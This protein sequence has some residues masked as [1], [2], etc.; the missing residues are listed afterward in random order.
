MELI[1]GFNLLSYSHCTSYT[2]A[3]YIH[4]HFVDNFSIIHTYVQVYVSKTGLPKIALVISQS[5]TNVLLWVSQW[6]GLL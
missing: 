4:I 1:V 5:V 3:L 2:I 6:R